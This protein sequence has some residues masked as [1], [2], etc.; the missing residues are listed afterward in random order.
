M[1]YKKP[2]IRNT[3]QFWKKDKKKS[4]HFEISK[5]QEIWRLVSFQDPK[6]LRLNDFLLAEE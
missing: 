1:N 3:S 4:S 2:F 5:K 6:K